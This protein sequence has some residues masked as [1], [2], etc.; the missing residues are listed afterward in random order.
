MA[1]G[2]FDLFP[3]PIIHFVIACESANRLQCSSKPSRLY[4]PVAFRSFCTAF[5]AMTIQNSVHSLA[6]GQ[7]VMLSAHPVGGARTDFH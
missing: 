5:S 1:P 2:Y 6:Y 4:G 7:L 3:P